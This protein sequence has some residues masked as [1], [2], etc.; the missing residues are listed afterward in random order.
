VTA[1][2]LSFWKLRELLLP[3]ALVSPGKARSIGES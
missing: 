3:N 2:P 1:D